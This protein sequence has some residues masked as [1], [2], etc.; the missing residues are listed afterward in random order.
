MFWDSAAL[1][2]SLQSNLERSLA[3]L[4]HLMS[5]PVWSPRQKDEQPDSPLFLL[6]QL[7]VRMAETNHLRERPKQWWR[8]HFSTFYYDYCKH[9][10]KHIYTSGGWNSTYSP[11]QFS[12]EFT[13]LVLSP[14]SPSMNPSKSQIWVHF[15]R[16]GLPNKTQDAQGN[17][18]CR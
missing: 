1:S 14:I 10:S 9:V 18:N 17:L 15:L 4:R 3:E 2:C 8:G 13:I 5:L 11:L 12:R 6:S 7:S 16:A